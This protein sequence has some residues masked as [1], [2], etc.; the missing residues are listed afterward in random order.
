MFNRKNT[1]QILDGLQK[2]TWKSKLSDPKTILKA[3][4]LANK[5]Q[6]EIMNDTAIENIE[7]RLDELFKKLVSRNSLSCT[8]QSNEIRSEDILFF[9]KL[10]NE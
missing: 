10:N 2:D 7:E 1:K 8:S 3:A 9:G 6:K 4:Q 5:E